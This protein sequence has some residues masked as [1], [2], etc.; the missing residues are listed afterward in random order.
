VFGKLVR[1]DREQEQARRLGGGCAVRPR[2]CVGG[3]G[4]QQVPQRVGA[5]RGPVRGPHAEGARGAAAGPTV[6][7][8]A[9]N[10]CS[11]WAW[12]EADAVLFLHRRAPRRTV[13]A[14]RTS[15]MCQAT[16]RTRPASSGSLQSV[17]GSSD[18]APSCRRHLLILWTASR[19]G[20]DELWQASVGCVQRDGSRRGRPRGGN[21]RVCRHGGQD[22]AWMG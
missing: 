3:G 5:C 4:A 12:L 11:C 6:L 10:E 22:A 9:G 15:P 17:G 16:L 19:L 2:K 13:G 7:R 18:R 21:G 8:R 20:A 14:R 1:H